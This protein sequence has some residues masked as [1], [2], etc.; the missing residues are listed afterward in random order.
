MC[1][2]HRVSKDKCSGHYIR[3]VVLEQLVWKNIQEDISAITCHEA[4]FRSEME[5][6][7]VCR[8]EESLW[9]YRKRLTQAEK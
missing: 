5:K 7:S 3:A 9:L 2:S 8:A 6:S 4:Y 1:S